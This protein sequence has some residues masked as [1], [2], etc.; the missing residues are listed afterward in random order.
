MSENAWKNTDVG[1]SIEELEISCEKE[2]PIELTDK[3]TGLDLWIIVKNIS[4]VNRPGVIRHK[5]EGVTVNLNKEI[6]MYYTSPE[7]IGLYCIKD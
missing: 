6:E 3:E 7:N 1:P 4:P 5:I 2:L